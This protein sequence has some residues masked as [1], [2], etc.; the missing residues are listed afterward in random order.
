MD[1][2]DPT[3]KVLY[4]SFN[5]Y[6][7]FLC[8]VSFYWDF[9]KVAFEYFFVACFVLLLI[10]KFKSATCQYSQPFILSC[11]NLYSQLNITFVLIFRS[12]IWIRCIHYIQFLWL[13]MGG[14]NPSSH[15]RRKA[16][17]KVLC[18]LQGFHA[19]NSH[20]AEHGG[21]RIQMQKDSGC[22]LHQLLQQ[23]LLWIRTGLRPPPTY[24]KKGR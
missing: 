6:V 11:R 5:S 22:C 15:S 18:T 21:Q 3:G 12:E 4:L 20:S 1:I 16:R 2:P 9:Y 17:V 19:W 7:S 14:E 23:Q 24:G 13:G 8:F 10:N